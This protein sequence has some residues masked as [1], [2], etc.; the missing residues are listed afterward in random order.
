M[1]QSVWLMLDIC[2]LV[3]EAAFAAK[4]EDRGS[5]SD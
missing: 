3:T 5:A 4:V 2:N 1:F